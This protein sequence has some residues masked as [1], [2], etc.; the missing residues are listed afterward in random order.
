MWYHT[1][2]YARGLK[3][4]F[5]ALHVSLL[6]ARVLREMFISCHYVQGFYGNMTPCVAMCKGVKDRRLGIESKPGNLNGSCER[7][8]EAGV[9]EFH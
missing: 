8:A 1:N 6:C 7:D 4:L 3:R 5:V 9:L 2:V